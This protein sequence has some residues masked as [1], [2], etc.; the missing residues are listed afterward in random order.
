MV[1]TVSD[2]L[3]FRIMWTIFSKKQEKKI[4]QF[5]HAYACK[6]AFTGFRQKM[7]KT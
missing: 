5:W 3:G 6:Y 7:L 2:R 4:K 1:K